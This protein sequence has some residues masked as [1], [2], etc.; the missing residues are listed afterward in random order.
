MYIYDSLG[1]PLTLGF[2]VDIEINDLDSFFNDERLKKKK[3]DTYS[4][5][6]FFEDHCKEQVQQVIEIYS[7]YELRVEKVKY[8]QYLVLF[9]YINVITSR[10]NYLY[11]KQLAY[12]YYWNCETLMFHELPKSWKCS[13]GYRFETIFL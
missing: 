2:N 5:Q 4:A 1:T 7:S 8:I 9:T 13:L 11:D 6:Q 3:A 12:A 10:D